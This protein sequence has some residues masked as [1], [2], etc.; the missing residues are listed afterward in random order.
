MPVPAK[1]SQISNQLSILSLNHQNQF[2]DDPKLDEATRDLIKTVYQ[3]YMEHMRPEIL[4]D[5]SRIKPDSQSSTFHE[6]LAY[7]SFYMRQHIK[8]LENLTGF[9]FWC[10]KFN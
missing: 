8:F 1:M 2:E 10:L 3:S 6:I 7:L 5:K 4:T 9:G